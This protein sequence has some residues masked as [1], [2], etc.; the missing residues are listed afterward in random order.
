VLI[1]RGGADTIV[2]GANLTAADQ[3]DGSA[4]SDKVTLA[5]NYSAGLIFSATTMVNVETLTL[6][7]GFA[8]NL[9]TDDATVAAGTLTVSGSGATAVTFNGTAETNGSFNITSGTGSD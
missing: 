4:G 9:T 7:A 2:M 1:A 6:G 8:Y 5:G 3:I